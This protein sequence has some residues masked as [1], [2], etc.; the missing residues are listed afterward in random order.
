MKKSLVLFIVLTLSILMSNVSF[1]QV[2]P[3]LT[4]EQM[5]KFIT[6]LKT[7]KS[8]GNFQLIKNVNTVSLAFFNKT[9]WVYKM[10]AKEG[11]YEEPETEI[12]YESEKD[13]EDNVGDFG[14]RVCR[15]VV[16]QDGV[17]FHLRSND[18]NSI[19]Q[20]IIGLDLNGRFSFIKESVEGCVMDVCQWDECWSPLGNFHTKGFGGHQSLRVGTNPNR[21]DMSLLK[22]LKNIILLN[23]EESQFISDPN[24][25]KAW[26]TVLKFSQN[27][28]RMENWMSESYSAFQYSFT[29]SEGERNIILINFNFEIGK[30]EVKKIILAG[31]PWI[32]TTTEKDGTTMT[33][34]TPN[35]EA[36]KKRKELILTGEERINQINS[37]IEEISGVEKI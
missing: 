27:G 30:I 1:P 26:L 32:E 12:F 15:V 16:G 6:A 11:T 3:S 18:G 22:I 20:V 8:I 9:H 2:V 37:L 7:G 4:Q 31:S 10:D 19:L 25:M 23:I 14:S 34:L 28:S 13:A 5:Q 36:Y 24:E 17:F 35:D 33:I 29:K 21:R